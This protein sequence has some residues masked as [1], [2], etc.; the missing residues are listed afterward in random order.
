MKVKGLL[1]LAV[2][3]AVIVAATAL[4]ATSDNV[5]RSVQA[6][7]AQVSPTRNAVD[8]R[9]IAKDVR[10]RAE[11]SDTSTADL[12]NSSD[13]YA[14]IR[15]SISAARAGD[16]DAQF[17]I[18]RATDY[19]AED[20]RF[21]F[22]RGERTLSLE[23]GLAWAIRRNVPYATAQR[24]YDRCR[25]FLES[26]T[27]IDTAASIQ[28]LNAAAA[29]GD[30]IA[31]AVLAA[32][33]LEAD[34]LRG[35]ADASGAESP[36]AVVENLDYTK[37]P[38]ELLQS[39]I[40]S[41]EPEVLFKIGDMMTLLDPNAPDVSVQRLAWMAVACERGLD[42]SAQ[43]D[44]VA[45]SCLTAECSS[46]N[47]NTEIVRIIAGDRWSEVQERARQLGEDL[48]A[49]RWDELGLNPGTAA[50]NVQE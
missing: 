16:A 10:P 26:Q 40:K 32:K 2:I 44:W 39:A 23:E 30:P 46:I 33:I 5:A 41:R 12:S 37:S 14:F 20:G 24:V 34:M 25:E 31:Q 9:A 19:C 27:P 21:Y 17:S 3:G 1:V 28:W 49:G 43:A 13:Y 36:R 18:W 15:N 8:S 50:D 29:Q 22:V 48:D 35:F 47:S 4:R 6:T 45:A 38:A 42:C 7:A 11:A